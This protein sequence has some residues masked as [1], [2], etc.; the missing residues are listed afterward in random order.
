[1]SEY[2]VSI[3]M[4]VYNAQKYLTDSLESIVNQSIGVE[5]L[6]VIIVND[7]S[8]DFFQLP[9]KFFTQRFQNPMQELCLEDTT[10][11]MMRL[12]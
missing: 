7:A 11:Y 12:P 3:I 10:E 4:P 2:K 5:N 1:M 8:T 9:V 6:E